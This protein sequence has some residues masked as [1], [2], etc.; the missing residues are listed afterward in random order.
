MIWYVL[1][2]GSLAFLWMRYRRRRS[3][4]VTQSADVE[5]GLP[6]ASRRR[7]F[8]ELAR[9]EES[10][11]APLQSVRVNSTFASSPAADGVSEKVSV[12]LR[13]QVPLRDEPPRSWLGGLPRLPEGVEW[14]CGVNPEKRDAGAVP[15]HFVAQVCCADLPA[16]LWGGLGPRDG[17]LL[18]FVNGNI[19]DNDDRGAW[20]ILHVSELGEE[21]QPPADIGPIHDGTY[22]GST[23]WTLR[24]SVYPRW[25]V[26][27]VCVPNDLRVENGRSLAAPA[28]F[29]S[30][31]YKGLPVAPEDRNPQKL[32]PFTWRCVA[33]ALDQM[34]AELQKPQP[35]QADRYTQQMRQKLKE[36]GAFE[37][38]V[39]ALERHEAEFWQKYGSMLNEP[40]PSDLDPKER[41]RR[42]NMRANADGRAA[43]IKEVAALL[44]ANPTPEALIER[45]EQERA[46]GWRVQ[47]ADHLGR[48]HSNVGREQHD[49][50]IAAEDWE[51]IKQQL[52]DCDHE[53]WALAWG[54]T[55]GSKL[56]VTVER[57]NMSVVERFNPVFS[58]TSVA[59]ATRY[60]FDPSK[61]SLIPAE[62]VSALEAGWRQLYENRP[63]RM[64]GYHD[65]LQSDAQPGPVD[66]LL[67]M[68][69]ATDYPMHWLWGDC[70]AVYCFISPSD[71]E[72]RA[73]DHAEF[74]LECH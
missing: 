59:V 74:H 30:T 55:E 50:P 65:G 63:H 64:G 21:R 6:S 34:I 45:L 3:T 58:A 2:F 70:G 17:W 49:S 51:A 67:L 71:L 31:L 13:R 14:P 48:C 72:Q 28:N 39:P 57:R 62:A 53:V 69:F 54:R 23:E 16:D 9:A 8:R 66:K 29:A 15:L 61:R 60:Y 19:C 22:T 41:V 37:D 11:A 36:P 18:L 35:P 52:T 26:D 25:P 20:R 27:V 68:Q 46:D 7:D 33:E 56:P 38:I 10:A 12:V 5:S 24:E 1:F 4:N 40:E 73:W 43:R 42:A 44:A 47:A 32:E